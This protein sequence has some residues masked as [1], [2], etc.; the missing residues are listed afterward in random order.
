MTMTRGE[1]LPRD[2]QDMVPRLRERGR[3]AG[4]RG[5]YL[6]SPIQRFHRDANAL[7][8][9][10]IFEYDHVANLYGGTF[11]DVEIPR[12]AMI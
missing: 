3:A 8:T 1:Q 4:S 6:D 2:L 5:T 7:A 11:L 10:A 9:H 12:N